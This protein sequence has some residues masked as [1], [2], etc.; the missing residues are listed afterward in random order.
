M[1]RPNLINGVLRDQLLTPAFEAFSEELTVL[2]NQDE[3]FDLSVEEISTL[4][5]MRSELK[6]YGGIN[7]TQALSLESLGCV[8]LPFSALG[9]SQQTSLTGYKLTQESIGKAI[10]DGLTKFYALLLELLQQI[11]ERLFG[12]KARTEK[13]KEDLK[14][15]RGYLLNQDAGIHLTPAQIKKAALHVTLLAVRADVFK[16]VCKDLLNLRTEGLKLTEYLES[17]AQFE[18]QCHRLEFH[19]LK[20]FATK[21]GESL[22]KDETKI[23]TVN[24]VRFTLTKA[25]NEASITIP[26]FDQDDRLVDK[27]KLLRYYDGLLD[28]AMSTIG[29]I[30]STLIG[31]YSYVNELKALVIKLKT[32][33]ESEPHVAKHLNQI[34][35]LNSVCFYLVR[36]LNSSLNIS[37]DLREPA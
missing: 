8:T 5:S 11:K 16:G 19:N 9:Y 12:T 28:R 6:R 25:L 17:P 32:A 22:Y 26:G 13:T 21:V 3:S 18:S 35:K 24:G 4:C 7:R 29:T 14:A 10:V 33:A 20:A 2:L 1:S 31:L 23:P 37:A 27:E 30:E 36:W 15:A 34:L